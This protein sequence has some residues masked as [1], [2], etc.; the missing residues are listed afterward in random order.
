MNESLSINKNIQS[1]SR[2]LFSL[3]GM[4]S[5]SCTAMAHEHTVVLVGSILQV[6]KGFM[7]GLECE[8]PAS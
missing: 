8:S 4:S 2:N 7:I 3:P 5:T 1:G 6:F